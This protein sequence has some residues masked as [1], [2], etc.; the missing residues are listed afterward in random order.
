MVYSEVPN[1]S[2]PNPE[3]SNMDQMKNK[4]VRGVLNLG[5]SVC[6]HVLLQDALRKDRGKILSTFFL[7]CM[8]TDYFIPR[9]SVTK[10]TY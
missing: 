2:E 6:K 10:E 4:T 7:Y 1:F 9:Y 8:L 5:M 3:Y